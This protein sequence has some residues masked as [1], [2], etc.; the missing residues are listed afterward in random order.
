MDEFIKQVLT[1]ENL[2]DADFE[3]FVRHDLA[4]QQLIGVVG[5]VG[6]LVTP[7]EAAGFYNR[8][9]QEF[10]RRRFSFPRRIIWRKSPRRP[11]PSRSFT[12]IFSPPIACR[13]A[14]R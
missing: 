10:P 7:Q 3:R 4:L 12:R 14:W 6:Q 11:K 8:E 13:I 9:H 2:T 1:P 5:V